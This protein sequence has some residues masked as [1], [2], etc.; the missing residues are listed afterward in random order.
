MDEAPVGRV[1]D[2]APRLW[3]DMCADLETTHTMYISSSCAV[4]PWI[5]LQALD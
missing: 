5:E 4:V 2:G 1:G 3:V